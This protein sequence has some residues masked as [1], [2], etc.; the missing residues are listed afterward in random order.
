MCRARKERENE[1]ER[2]LHLA[3]LDTEEEEEEGGRLCH[4]R[5]NFMQNQ[6]LL[7]ALATPEVG[8]R[9]NAEMAVSDRRLD[10]TR[11]PLIR[12]L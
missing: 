8:D 1:R 9:N 10:S 7:V 3:D 6:S 5:A 12:V 2:R 11:L 4:L